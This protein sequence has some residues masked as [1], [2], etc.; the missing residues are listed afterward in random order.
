M[1]WPLLYTNATWKSVVSIGVTPPQ[2]LPGSSKLDAPISE[3][4][5]SR[6]RPYFWQW[7]KL[8]GKSAQEFLHELVASWALPDPTVLPVDVLLPIPR[9]DGT[10]FD[11][12]PGSACLVPATLPLDVNA[13]QIA[14]WGDA[15]REDLQK[16]K[17][18]FYFIK[19]TVGAETAMSKE[20]P[21]A[22]HGEEPGAQPCESVACS[23]LSEG[24]AGAACSQS[25]GW[26]DGLL[27]GSISDVGAKSIIGSMK[28][29]R[30]PFQDVHLLSLVGNGSFGKV[31]HGL[32]FGSPVAVKVILWHAALHSKMTPHVEAELSLSLGHPN[33][34][35][36]FMYSSRTKKNENAQSDVTETWLIQEWCDRGTLQQLFKK[37]RI[38]EEG[39]S[40]L[41]KICTEISAAGAYL[42]SR[43]V[44]HGDLTAANVLIKSS[45]L[46]KGYT[47]KLC[48]FGL[49]RVLEGSATEIIT[50]QLGTVTH[51]P[52]ELFNADASL[53]KL[54]R[55]AD[56]Y[57]LGVLIWH[58]MMGQVPFRSLTPPQ[59]VLK[60]SMGKGLKLSEN[61]HSGL[62]SVFDLCVAPDPS[63]RPDFKD[64]LK[65]LVE[66]TLDPK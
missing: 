36:T 23:A 12:I 15:R 61:S 4:L 19:L 53:N 42:H 41:A 38:D 48:D 13:A 33:L 26:K 50:A 47:T 31:Y 57:A 8:K 3:S 27:V 58:G 43:G 54:T 63:Y 9:S 25:F 55:K 32:W 16:L 45:S 1:K 29:P 22:Q 62:K 14:S 2:R 6:L 37:P 5:L 39:T 10:S 30:P 18:R 60:V 35:Q 7:I 24:L 40:E 11:R 28:P 21:E 44:I 59:V 17:S 65:I 56:V 51:M 49:S 66:F 34:V 64:V 46:P 52:P 20:Q